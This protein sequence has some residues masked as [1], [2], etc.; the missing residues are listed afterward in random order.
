MSVKN[1]RKRVHYLLQ[2]GWRADRAVQGLG[3]THRSNQKQP[4][5]YFLVTTD[6]K[7]QKRF[8]SSIARRL[9]QLG[10]LTKG[11]RQTGSQGIFQAKD[12]LESSYAMDALRIFYE[13]L[14][15]GKMEGFTT[16]EFEQQTGLSLTDDRTG[17]MVQSLPPIRQF[18]NRLLSLKID[19]QNQV[20]DAFSERMDR[21]IQAHMD[22][23]DLD[24]GL[25]TVKGK[26]IKKVLKRRSIRMKN[27]VQ[28]RSISNSMSKMTFISIHGTE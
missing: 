28:K 18:L 26:S 5:K 16:A 9:D 10:A 21:V 23:G 24:Q 14:I 22:A 19:L 6:L 12:N 27:Q 15:R 2:A 25:E 1:Q 7:G 13:D 11:Q 3:R 17:G 4:P 20:F 8:L